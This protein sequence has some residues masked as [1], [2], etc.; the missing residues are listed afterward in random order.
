MPIIPATQEELS[1]SIKVQDGH[2]KMEDLISKITKAKRAGGMGSSGREPYTP[3][4]KKKKR[5][6]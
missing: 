2:A 1:R 4:H 5:F 6:K 3:Y